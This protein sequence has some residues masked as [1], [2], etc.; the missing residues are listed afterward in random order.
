M[1]PHDPTRYQLGL[2]EKIDALQISLILYK[3]GFW[4]ALGIAVIIISVSSF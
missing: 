3:I 4:I 1:A 2:E